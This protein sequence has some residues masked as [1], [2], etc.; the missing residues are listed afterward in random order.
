MSSTNSTIPFAGC[1]T[2]KRAV[3]L[4]FVGIPDDSQSSYRAGCAGGPDTIR[5]AYD[6]R[7]F[8]STTESGVNLAES[9]LDFGN[10]EAKDTW[11]ARVDAYRD[12]I[13][14]LVEEGKRVFV[15]GGDHAI[16]VPVVDAY[17]ALGGPIHVVQI[18]AHPDLYFDFEGSKDSH[19]CV[20]ARLLEMSHVAS[21]TQL[22]IRTL[23]DTQKEQVEQYRD[24]LQI[25]FARDL[26]GPLPQL[27]HIPDKAPVYLTVDLDGIDPGF[28][29][30]VS[31][32][33]PGGLT[34]RQVSSFLQRSRWNL[35]GMDV[36]ELNPSTDLQD[37]TAIL[38]ARLLHEGMGMVAKELSKG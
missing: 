10:L 30:G 14:S 38:A 22:G 28:A 1:F 37:F 8:N 26:E 29:P 33:V 3:P 34:P 12:A 2:S 16:T 18:D 15:A 4:V 36:V 7:S 5:S 24:R 21:V 9:V 20:A 13:R 32:P 6:G 27:D 17:S 11:E 25:H 31:H 19:A 23:N 35:V